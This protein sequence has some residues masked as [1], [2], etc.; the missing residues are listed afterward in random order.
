MFDLGRSHETRWLVVARHAKWGYYEPF[1]NVLLTSD[2]FARC[3]GFRQGP[4]I[5]PARSDALLESAYNVAKW[6]STLALRQL[7]HVEEWVQE[8]FGFSS[9][10]RAHKLLIMQQTR[11]ELYKA[12]IAPYL[13]LILQGQVLVLKGGD[14][15]RSV[16]ILFQQADEILRSPS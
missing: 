8:K 10:F 5:Y 3:K 6:R 7:L 4:R 13:Q 11:N 14:R 16:R 2:T 12:Q 9:R 15:R 1:Y